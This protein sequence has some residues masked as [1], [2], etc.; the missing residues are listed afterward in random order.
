[1]FVSEVTM[2]PKTVDGRKFVEHT[3]TSKF[4]KGDVSIT[5]IFMN[6]KPI[7]KHY[8]FDGPDAMRSFWKD[9]SSP[10]KSVT[11]FVVPKGKGLDITV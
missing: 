5:T 9:L 2:V 1:M 7:L 3:I 11:D 4:K 10:C 6:D 8:I